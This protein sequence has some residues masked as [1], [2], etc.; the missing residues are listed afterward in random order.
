MESLLLGPLCGNSSLFDRN[1][2]HTHLTPP[3]VG[4]AP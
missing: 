3:V 4:Y 1:V 2:G